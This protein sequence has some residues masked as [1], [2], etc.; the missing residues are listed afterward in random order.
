MTKGKKKLRTSNSGQLL[1]VAALAIAILISSTTVYVYELSRETNSSNAASIA[2]LILALKQNT[3]NTMISSLANVSNGGE[4]A[5]LT[6]NLNTLAQVVRSLTHFGTLVLD[7]AT[8][9]DSNYDSG[10]W[11]SWNTS[12]M[13]TSSTDANFT[14]RV[15]G[16]ETTIA[17]NYEINVTTKTTIA[18]FYVTLGGSEKLVNLTCSVFN[19]EKSALAKNITLL[20]QDSGSWV[21][22]DSSNNL[23]VIDRGN[24]TYSISFTIQTTAAI[25]PVSAHTYD[26]RN[27]FVQANTTCSAA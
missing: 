6:A 21:N 11:L 8:L 13:G 15:Y 20:Y 24:G 12:D 26:M 16:E 17:A 4:R 19:E 3:R 1:I 23:S 5:V 2:D 25:I 22:V 14:L 18:G 7:F 10:I 9:N 27:I